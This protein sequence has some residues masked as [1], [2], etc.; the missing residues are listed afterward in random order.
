LVQLFP[1]E[2]LMNHCRHCCFDAATKSQ[3]RLT[4]G[5]SALPTEN[6]VTTPSPE[7]KSDDFCP[8]SLC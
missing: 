2:V 6:A 5:M 8:N 4:Y 3:I 7:T 1:E